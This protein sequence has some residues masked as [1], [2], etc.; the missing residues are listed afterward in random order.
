LIICKIREKKTFLKERKIMRKR[1]L[2]LSILGIATAL[3]WLVQPVTSGFGVL[4]YADSAQDPNKLADQHFK[5]A[6]DLLKQTQYQDA[7]AEYEKVISLLPDSEIGLDARYWIGQSYFQM[8]KHDEALSIFKKLI[9]EYPGSAI[10]P[11]TQLMIARV[12]KDKEISKASARR[13]ASVDKKTIVDPKTGATY[14]RIAVLTGKKD[15]VDY[16][17]GHLILSPNGKFLLF[18]TLV[19]PL[20]SGE[21]FE[22]TDMPV[23]Y[24]AWS[25]DGKKIVFTS[26]NAIWM[27]PVSPETARPTSPPKKLLD[28]DAPARWSP[29]SEKISFSRRDEGDDGGIWT[30]SIKD[31]TLHQVL[32]DTI[33]GNPPIWS[34]DGKSFVYTRVNRE[35]CIV[36]A[37][38]GNPRKIVDYGIPISFSF[39][40]KWL[41]FRQG[42]RSRLLRLADEH[43]FEIIPTNGTGAF[44]AWSPDGKKMI[45][46][47]S[48]Y[49]YTCI[50]KVVSTTGGPSFQLG[51]NLILWPYQHF[52]TPDSKMIITHGGESYD[53][54]WM[55]P[56]EGGEAK[57]LDIR[58]QLS[59][60]LV[61]RS[62]TRDCK[63]ILLVDEHKVEEDLFVA[64]VSLK[65]GQTISDAVLAF[66]KRDILPVGYGRRD[67]WEWSPDGKK[68]AL[69]HEGDIWIKPIDKGEPVKI[70]NSPAYE[71][72]PVWS[73]DNKMIAFT[74]RYNEE[75]GDEQSLHIISVSGGKADKIL[76]RAG[77]ELFAWSPDGKEL[78]FIKDGK[79]SVISIKSGKVREIVDFFNEGFSDWFT[80]LCWLPDGKHFAFVGE[81]GNKIFLVSA[82]EGKVIELAADDEGG[83][84]W[85]YPSPDGKWLSFGSEGFVK[86]RSQATIWEVEVEDLIKEK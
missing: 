51:R 16:P 5:K 18:D 64:S 39:N 84:N 53:M 82:E 65:D 40:G 1:C 62:L 9:Q 42:I 2:T 48:S 45:N 46:Y 85:L 75:G 50:L 21:P 52:W 23:G 44:L 54:F 80:C 67:E 77:K 59:G 14:K 34:P 6:I 4:S 68:L 7:I 26:R 79:L 28:Y 69:V 12:E 74:V 47:S 81:G 24:C 41:F 71:T 56:L 73:P 49:D 27:I 17:L 66:E 32:N 33:W 57:P 72:F 13:D 58:V 29:D 30:L 11:V 22:L 3:F 37:E 61:P 76:D 35:M 83:K 31:G 10:A 25:P 55:I 20:R 38:G 19:I 8:G 70:T 15:V 63:R 78:A 86:T 43:V 36:P 60:K